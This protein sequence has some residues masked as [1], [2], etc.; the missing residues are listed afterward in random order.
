MNDWWKVGLA[1]AAGA[2]LMALTGGA[3]APGLAG[4]LGGGGAAGAAGAGAAGA[5]G[6]AGMGSAG[7]GMAGAGLL[8]AETAGAAGTGLGMLA[9]E[10]AAAVAPGATAF[11]TPPVTGGAPLSGMLSGTALDYGT[12]AMLAESS[13]GAA[14]A[15]PGL[16][17]QA[18]GYA[19]SGMK[20]ASTYGAVNNAMG[21]N[22]PQAQAPMGRPVFQGEAPQISTGM[23]QPARDQNAVLA[24]IAR[25][26]QR[27]AF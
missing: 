25:R 3:A 17:A 12:Q 11:V 13:A 18:G 26:R 5:A 4:L 24:A 6:A 19:K 9:P 8:G 15:Q 22:Q 20:A 27:G 1:G 2:G 21:G 10:G 23:A 16:M 7:A 14:A